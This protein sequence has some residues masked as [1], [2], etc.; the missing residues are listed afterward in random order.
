MTIITSTATA[1]RIFVPGIKDTRHVDTSVTIPAGA[2]RIL[3]G[4]D[5]P[6]VDAAAGEFHVYVGG[7]GVC[8]NHAQ[9]VG[10]GD[11]VWTI[12]DQGSLTGTKMAGEAVE[13][14]TPLQLNPEGTCPIRL[15]RRMIHIKRLAAD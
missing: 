7:E 3:L 2:T 10:G 14:P 1:L 5:Y 4:C 11:G 15:G 13:R 12:E 9:L 8:P 6:D